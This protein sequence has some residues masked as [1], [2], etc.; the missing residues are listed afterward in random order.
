MVET[1]EGQLTTANT[2]RVQRQLVNP[3]GEPHYQP[4]CFT[5]NWDDFD[6]TQVMEGSQN[7]E[8]FDKTPNDDEIIVAPQFYNRLTEAAA[9]SMWIPRLIL[10][11]VG[12]RA[13]K[14][15]VTKTMDRAR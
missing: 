5:S 13:Q 1:A 9:E 14:F 4:L 3:V 12:S 15:T 10:G 2:S 6:F 11:I 7:G 8:G